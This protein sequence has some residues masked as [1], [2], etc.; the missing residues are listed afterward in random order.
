M[1]TGSESTW[2]GIESF[3]KNR[4]VWQLYPFGSGFEASLLEEQFRSSKIHQDCGS[5][6]YVSCGLGKPRYERQ[7]KK[8]RTWYFSCSH[9]RPPEFIDRFWKRF[10]HFLLSVPLIGVQRGRKRLIFFILLQLWPGAAQGSDA[11]ATCTISWSAN[12]GVSLACLLELLAWRLLVGECSWNL[13]VLRN[14]YFTFMDDVFFSKKS[15]CL[16]TDRGCCGET[17]YCFESCFIIS[18]QLWGART[19]GWGI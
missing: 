16:E 8:G 12:D 10:S 7:W 9:C 15:K 17:F 14:R 13:G 6:E 4:T 18:T 11:C 3:N 2:E 5:V 1:A 19:P